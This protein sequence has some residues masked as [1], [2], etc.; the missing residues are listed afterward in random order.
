MAIT[1]ETHVIDVE[2]G[3]AIDKNTG[4]IAGVQQV[5][6]PKADPGIEFPKWVVVHDS[7]VFRKEVDGA[8]AVVST[9]GFADY[10]VNRANGEITVLVKNEDEEKIATSGKE[11]VVEE[12]VVDAP[13]EIIPPVIEGKPVTAVKPA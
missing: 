12:P 8:P 9:P 2:T 3:F 1:P 10:H 7:H 6:L 5:V 13:I 4:A 11:V